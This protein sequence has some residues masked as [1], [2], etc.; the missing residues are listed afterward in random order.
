MSARPIPERGTS[1][2]ILTRWESGSGPRNVPIR[3]P[4]GLAGP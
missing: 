4:S 1:V 2:T 3:R